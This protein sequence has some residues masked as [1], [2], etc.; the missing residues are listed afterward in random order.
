MNNN[1]YISINYKEISKQ[2]FKYS[3]KNVI[4]HNSLTVEDTFQESIFNVLT[5]VIIYTGMTVSNFVHT[6][7]SIK[8]KQKKTIQTIVYNDNYVNDN[9]T[10]EDNNT[11]NEMIDK[12][13]LLFINYRPDII[14]K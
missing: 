7:K 8:N 3:K 10:I 9:N 14:T 5:D 2:Y 4:N 11:N 1:D 13:K 12:L 6:L